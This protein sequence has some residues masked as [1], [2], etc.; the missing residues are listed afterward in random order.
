MKLKYLFI[1]LIWIGLFVIV[2]CKKDAE[3]E[4]TTA[5]KIQAKWQIDNIVSNGHFSGEDH[6]T[7]YTGT[8]SDYF[9]IRTDGKISSSFSG[10]TTTL[11]YTIL[12]DSKIILDGSD[13]LTIKNL[14]ENTIVLYS[15]EDIGVPNP[16][17]YTEGTLN[18]KK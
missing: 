13:T 16:G 7:T 18:L 14:T 12:G 3:K 17:D 9:D 6:K 11:E 8:A 4:K 10:N 2:S 15:K 1:V 5:E